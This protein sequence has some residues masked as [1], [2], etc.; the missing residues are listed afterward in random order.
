MIPVYAALSKVV[1]ALSPGPPRVNIDAI[2]GT[3]LHLVKTAP[4]TFEYRIPMYY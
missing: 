3:R 2:R 4:K 1:Y